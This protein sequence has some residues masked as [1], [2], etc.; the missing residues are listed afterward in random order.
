MGGHAPYAQLGEALADQRSRSFRAI[1][2]APRRPAQPV[3]DLGL[4]HAAVCRRNQPEPAEE[5]PG[6]PLDCRPEPPAVELLVE[7]QEAGQDLA[8]D[9]LEGGGHDLGQVAH[10]LWVAVEGEQVVDVALGEL[11]EHQPV[12]FQEDLH[13]PILPGGAP[14]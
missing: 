6:G 13:R 4:V 14:A 10:D 5:L 12:S 9:Y 8:A 3:T 11:A 1:P 2:L 7:A